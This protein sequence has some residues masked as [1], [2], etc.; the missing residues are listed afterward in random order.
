MKLSSVF[1][2]T[3]SSCSIITLTAFGFLSQAQAAT[4]SG[5]SSGR[6]V[7]PT[8]ENSDVQLVNTGVGTNSFTWGEPV[9]GTPDN[10]LVFTGNSFLA[11]IGSWFEIGNLTYR[12]G[13]V[14]ADTGVDKVTLNLDLY[15]DDQVPFSKV[16][17]ISFQLE[18]TLNDSNI[19]LKDPRNADYVEWANF[20]AE[21]S[22]TIA[23]NTYTLELGGLGQDNQNKLT[24][25]EGDEISAAFYA[26]IN[27]SPPQS[28]VPS[29]DVPEPTSI[30]GSLLVGSYLIYRKKLYKVKLN[31][32]KDN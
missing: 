16:F 12:N 26:R 5:K 24:V 20:L 8:V 15:F 6:W 29:K 30:I 28:G 32:H 2:T 23:G 13:T 7:N 4:V 17:P 1:A 25:L 21:P 3:L 18:N 31:S 11:D 27:T 14:Y 19:D 9:P 10:Q 22:F